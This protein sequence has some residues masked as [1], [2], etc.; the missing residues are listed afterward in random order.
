LLNPFSIDKTKFS[1]YKNITQA[2]GAPLKRAAIIKTRRKDYKIFKENES[3]A[4]SVFF[5]NLG[6]NSHKIKPGSAL[7]KAFPIITLNVLNRVAK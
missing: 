3:F 6:A 5:F 7:L 4:P 2:P 1:P